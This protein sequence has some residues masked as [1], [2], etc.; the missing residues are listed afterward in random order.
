MNMKNSRNSTKG[1]TLIEVMVAVTLV[2]GF[3][4][5]IFEVNGICL[6]Y[7]RASKNNLAVLQGIQDRLEQLRNMTYKSLT[8]ASAVS[9]LMATPANGSE[10]LARVPTEVVTLTGYQT[11]ANYFAGTADAT[12]T[13]IILSP[14]AAS[15]TVNTTDANLSSAA[16][17]KVKVTYT[18]NEIFGGRSR[19]EDSETLISAGTKK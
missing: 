2:V 11:I 18:W 16:I 4:V 10:F 9:N 8:N 5:S 19:S 7:M 1:T 15:A 6:R 12:K 13:Q 14:G 3:F 17:I